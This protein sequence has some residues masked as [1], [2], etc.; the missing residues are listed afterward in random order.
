MV[1]KLRLRRPTQEVSSVCCSLGFGRPG[2]DLQIL[3]VFMKF[4]TLLHLDERETSMY[5]A[6]SESFIAQVRLYLGCIRTLQ[7]S[8]EQNGI[9]LAILTNRRETL[10]NLLKGHSI[11]IIQLDF[12]MPVPSGIGFYADHF[13]AEAYG[14][15]A[16]LNEDYVGLVDSDMICINAVPQCLENLAK[17][18]T[19][20]YYDITDQIFPAFGQ[21]R[22]I[23]D[24]LL[25]SRKTVFGLWA[26]GEFMAG[27]PAF[28]RALHAEILS[29]L[30]RYW[31]AQKQLHHT[32]N[33][34]LASVGIENLINA[35]IY[36][37]ADAGRLK[38]VGR[39][40]S[41]KTL[42]FQNSVG[43]YR[44]CFLLHVPSE[45][46][47]LASLASRKVPNNKLFSLYQRH[48]NSLQPSAIS[49]VLGPTVVSNLKR[50]IKKGD[51][52]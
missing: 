37:V 1:P 12:R 19:G 13:K 15:F 42:H 48:L 17:S 52:R 46:K 28:F 38:I 24:K 29:F 23:S 18:Q 27:P 7:H 43:F 20:L 33:E 40:W 30:D 3:K 14:Y 31:R 51:P 22:I 16:G 35:S 9:E 45:K 39:H 6:V 10:E 5:N 25:V 2:Y 4:F 21:D 32:S 44:D 50:I 47:F 36:P 41:A 49:K 8:L 11:E 26:G 34:V